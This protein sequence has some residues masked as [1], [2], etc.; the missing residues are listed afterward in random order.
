MI[1]AYLFVSCKFGMHLK[2]KSTVLVKCSILTIII[3]DTIITHNNQYCLEISTISGLTTKR[4][5][6]K[7]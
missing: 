3:L 6:K 5:V 4:K 2:H 7:T 1:Y